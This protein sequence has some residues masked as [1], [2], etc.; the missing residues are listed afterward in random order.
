MHYN[1][2]YQNIQVEISSFFIIHSTAPYLDI[3]E[4][5]LHSVFSLL[6][7]VVDFALLQLGR[8]KKHGK[9]FGNI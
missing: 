7:S 6:Y 2:L 4:K 1:E 9:V 5:H 3:Q 8:R